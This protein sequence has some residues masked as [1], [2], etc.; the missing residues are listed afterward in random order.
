MNQET[1]RSDSD[2]AEPPVNRTILLRP[3][4]RGYKQQVVDLLKGLLAE[5]EAGKIVSVVAL[6]EEPGGTFRHTS[7]GCDNLFAQ[8]GGAAR[9]MHFINKRIDRTIK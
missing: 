4:E 1:E 2:D 9:M 6:C 5:A 3:V 8:L 7:S